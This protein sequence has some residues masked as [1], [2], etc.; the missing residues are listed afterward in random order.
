MFTVEKQSKPRTD[1]INWDG[2][3]RSISTFEVGDNSIPT[4][5]TIYDYCR[6]MVGNSKPGLLSS[7]L[8]YA[9][10]FNMKVIAFMQSIESD[11][12]FFLTCKA[13]SAIKYMTEQL[14][15]DLIVNF[16]EIIMPKLEE[17]V[18]SLVHRDEFFPLFFNEHQKSPVYF[19]ENIFERA[20]NTLVSPV[21]DEFIADVP[22]LINSLTSRKYD[23]RMLPSIPVPE[24]FKYVVNL[25]ANITYFRDL[26]CIDQFRHCIPLVI[27][28][29]QSNTNNIDLVKYSILLIN[30]FLAESVTPYEDMREKYCYPV[31]NIEDNPALKQCGIVPN[32]LNFYFSVLNIHQSLDTLIF[33]SI[34]MF[35]DRRYIA[36]SN[37][38]YLYGF[39]RVTLDYCFTTTNEEVILIILDIINEAI[40]RF[41]Q[42]VD[43]SFTDK[44]RHYSKLP[45]LHSLFPLTYDF[46]L[47]LK[48]MN[49]NNIL[50]RL[51]NC[52]IR[53]LSH[54][55]SHIFDSQC[56]I[57][58]NAIEEY[59]SYVGDDV[60]FPV[61]VTSFVAISRCIFLLKDATR[62][63][64]LM[65]HLL[66]F[67][68]NYKHEEEFVCLFLSLVTNIGVE[69]CSTGCSL[70][71]E[72]ISSDAF[73][74]FCDSLSESN[75]ENI[76]KSLSALENYLPVF[77]RIKDSCGFL[78]NS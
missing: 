62:R 32:I 12:D 53:L 15:I 78:L 50:H 44:D 30:N 5:Q 73:Q 14:S 69:M 37:C 39:Y 26:K 58:D 64:E 35:L 52:V 43:T 7:D 59:L 3:I 2:L 6:S 29:A 57:N 4:L 33:N 66:E 54:N 51:N 20:D 70:F 63:V 34:R 45:I 31:F 25:M 23:S 46:F 72:F 42:T 60:P 55:L 18:F 10:N 68:Q 38:I 17:K 41:E 61:R 47:H 48:K 36:A 74:T 76:S 22:G 56:F 49:D 9:N 67:V 75:D 16:F 65:R 40:K 21:R 71:W 27:A 24:G 1:K 13:V 8:F 77:E 28:I 19:I 11:E